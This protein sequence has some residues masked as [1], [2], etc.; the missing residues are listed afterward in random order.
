MDKTMKRALV[1]YTRY[2]THCAEYRAIAE[3]LGITASELNARIHPIYHA[4]RRARLQRR[5]A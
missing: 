5:A 4:R 2:Q 3:S 1:L